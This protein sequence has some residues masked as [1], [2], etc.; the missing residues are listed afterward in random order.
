MS[1]LCS[2]SRTTPVLFR[3]VA[4]SHQHT[5]GPSALRLAVQALTSTANAPRTIAALSQSTSNAI[6]NYCYTTSTKN[7]NI[8][9]SAFSAPVTP[10]CSNE[11]AA[12]AARTYATMTPEERQQEEKTG[13]N[14]WKTK[15]PYKLHEPNDGFKARYEAAC[16]CGK[17]EYEL[18]REEPL[19]SK[20]C[21][22]TTCQTQHA[23]PFQ[24]AAIFHKE[25]ISFKNGHHNLEWYDPSSKS[26]EHKLPCKVR[27]SFCH[28]PIMDEGRN[29]ILL[30]PSLI[31]FKSQQDKENFAPRLHM[32]YGQRCIDIPDGLP[33][34]TGL[35][36]ESDLIEDSPP[37]Q[38]K[39]HAR[40]R[41]QEGTVRVPCKI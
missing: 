39:E 34:W 2:L 29:M 33:K 6:L 36:N 18:S 4:F 5:T 21:H 9:A 8:P 12:A 22:C 14:D 20:L 1:G 23:A 30:F 25:D 13:L 26:T 41:E 37:E 11:T 3:R 24:W 7:A 35:N 16:H 17:V 15:A 38:V 28:S 10:D 27:C 32:F 40:Q 31:K 19:D